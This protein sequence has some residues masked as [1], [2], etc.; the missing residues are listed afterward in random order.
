MQGLNFVGSVP[1]D[2]SILTSSNDIVGGLETP[3]DLNFKINI[4]F[5]LVLVYSS[6]Y[7]EDWIKQMKT[8]QS[9]N[10]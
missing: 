3:I 6:T 1:T 2:L 7:T 4:L 8:I 10:W 5:I 9:I